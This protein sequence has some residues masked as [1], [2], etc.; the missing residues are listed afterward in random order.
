ML[1]LLYLV[2]VS[3][4]ERL[5]VTIYTESQC[6]DTIAL[7]QTSIKELIESP[8]LKEFLKHV[9]IEFIPFGNGQE[10]LNYDGS[11]KFTC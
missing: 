3:V 5:K 11:Y 9:D 7:Y 8:H 4:A 6:K 2:V 1:I 10:R